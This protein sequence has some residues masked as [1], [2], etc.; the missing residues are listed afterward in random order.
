MLIFLWVLALAPT[1]WSAWMF[2]LSV[3]G[4]K[5]FQFLQSWCPRTC[6]A[7]KF[8]GMH[9]CLINTVSKSFVLCFGCNILYLSLHFVVSL[10]PRGYHNNTWWEMLFW[11]GSNC[12]IQLKIVVQSSIHRISIDVNLFLWWEW[13]MLL[14]AMVS[15]CLEIDVEISRLANV[16][17]LLM[18]MLKEAYWLLLGCD[19]CP[20]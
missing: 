3:D 14:F 2:S 15:C 9:F 5:S 1:I 11:C 8:V 7:S 19:I 13:M 20:R 16:L 17:A 18:S 10:P 4:Y 12:Y 6:F